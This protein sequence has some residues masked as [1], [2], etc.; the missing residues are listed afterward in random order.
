M[1]ATL[2]LI[3][4]LRRS[5]NSGATPGGVVLTRRCGVDAAALRPISKM[6]GM[7]TTTATAPS[8]LDPYAAPEPDPAP[9]S[10]ALRLMAGGVA[11]AFVAAALV[12]SQAGAETH[13]RSVPLPMPPAAAGPAPLVVNGPGDVAV[14]TVVYEVGQTSGWHAHAG[15]HA[16]AVVSGELAVYGPDCVRRSVVP[17]DPYVGGQELHLARN[18][19]DR[20]VDMVVTYLNPAGRAPD[21]GNAPPPNCPVS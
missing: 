12:A 4:G 3:G 17:G 11:V 9:R 5:G 2:R 20:P 13:V 6:R 15:I 18:E 19:T 10:T 1:G 14:V 8:T 7:S 16:V 21:H